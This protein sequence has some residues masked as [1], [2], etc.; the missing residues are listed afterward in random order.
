M[1][2]SFGVGIVEFN[3]R[4]QLSAASAENSIESSQDSGSSNGRLQSPVPSDSRWSQKPSRGS[5]D[6]QGGGEGG[7]SLG[8]RGASCD[9]DG[10]VLNSGRSVATV[11]CS[12][13]ERELSSQGVDSK[14]ASKDETIL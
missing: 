12:N 4:K 13:E 1:G 2:D 3:S 9:P 6:A 14:T 11:W 5:L 10:S 8:S 7:G